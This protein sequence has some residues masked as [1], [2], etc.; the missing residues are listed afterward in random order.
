MFA[1][2][3]QTLFISSARGIAGARLNFHANFFCIDT[4]HEEVGCNGVLFNDIYGTP[5]L[6]V[7]VE[8]ADEIDAQ[9]ALMQEELK[10][11]GLAQS[12]LLLSYLKVF[13]I[14]ATRVKLQQQESGPS[15]GRCSQQVLSA[16]LKPIRTDEVLRRFQNRALAIER[17][18]L[19]PQETRMAL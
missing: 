5:V 14:K 2:P 9:I 7:P 17:L 12:E 3:Y 13:L 1:N 8:R 6:P 11:A 15:R 10:T 16:I 19:H 18:A 4:Y